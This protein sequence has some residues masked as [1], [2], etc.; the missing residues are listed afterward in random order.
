LG[1]VGVAVGTALLPLLSRQI[2]AGDEA[3][4][5]N[6]QNRAVEFSILLTLPAA[7]AL[8][9]MAD[10]VV[11]VLFQ[12]GA[13]GDVQA[14]ATAAALAILA[15]GLPGYVLIKALAPG[16]F[17]RGDTATPVKIAAVSMIV[18]VALSLILMGP[19][20]HVGIAMATAASS[21]LNAGVMAFVLHKRGHFVFDERLKSRL[22]R[23][24]LASTGMSMALYFA[25]AKLAPWLSSGVELERAFALAALVVGGLTSF[26]ALALISGAA[27]QS[28]VNNLRR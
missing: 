7:C 14:S 17:G 15:L 4:A 2:S 11:Q 6:S 1:V 18:N 22:P 3:A 20:L 8:F 10:P 27:E 13:F 16:F 21:W 23:T 25:T 12:R 9:V 19:Y 26:A 24:F 5:Q 28:D